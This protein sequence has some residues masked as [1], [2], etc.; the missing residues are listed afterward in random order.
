MNLESDQEFGCPYC[1]ELITIRV[2]ETGGRKQYFV[3]DC[4]VCCRPIGIEVDIDTDGY[5]NLIAKR[6]GEG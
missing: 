1:G 3:T 5:I 4:E 6:E 2:D